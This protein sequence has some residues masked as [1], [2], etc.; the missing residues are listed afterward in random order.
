MSIDPKPILPGVWRMEH[1]GFLVRA[2]IRDGRTREQVTIIRALSTETD[3]RRALAWLVEE[4]EKVRA[5][6]P[7]RQELPSMQRFCEFAA[8]LMESKIRAGDFASQSTKDQWAE[9][10][11]NRLYKAPFAAFFCDQIR[12]S[13]VLAWK[14]RISIGKGKGRYSPHTA[15]IWIKILRV[16]CKAYVQRYELER[17]PMLA[18]P[19]FET[20]R[21]RG[22]ITREQPNS[23][24]PQ[25]LPTFLRLFRELEPEHFAMAALGFAIGARPSSL[26]PLRRS[27]PMKD[28]DK[29]T[30][31]LILRR[32]HT[33]GSSVMD[34]TKNAEDV[35]VMLP[36]E[37]RAILAWHEATFLVP[38]NVKGTDRPNLTASKRSASELLFPSRKGGFQ[39]SSCLQKPFEAVS[40]AMKTETSGKF[41]KVITPKGMRRTNKDILRAAGV[42]DIVA[43][44]LNSHLTEGMHKHYSTVS[45]REMNEAVAAVIDLAGYRE[46]MGR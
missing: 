16:I 1:G 17:N 36:E 28:Y 12:A 3:P 40:E 44:A 34:T 27:G 37:L 4:R 25:E 6:I 33:R 35:I 2:R 31:E 9:I 11:T 15:N 26:R 23:L 45:Q 24:T 38:C 20:K 22:R 14:E 7:R 19:L 39:S 8:Q 10:L 5:G 32:S 42:R 43:M 13:D 18:V 30:G 21:W 29:E 46:A 41:T